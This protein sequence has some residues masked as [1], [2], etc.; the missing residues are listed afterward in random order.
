MLFQGIN[1]VSIHVPD[2][3]A[4]RKFYG[5]VLGLGKPEFDMPDIGWV[6]FRTGGAGNLAITTNETG[7]PASTRINVVLNTKDCFAT[8]AELRRRGVR[9]EEPQ[10]VPG[11]IVH[12]T[13][14]DPFG[15]RL[16]MCSEP[17]K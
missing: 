9:C 15:N 4:A 10:V 8:A 12:C 13:F 17:A 14:Y 7:Q 3:D 6:E 1:V 16:Q 5:E 2:L 11:V